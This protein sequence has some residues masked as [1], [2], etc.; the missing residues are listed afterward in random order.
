M[1]KLNTILCIAVVSLI[2]YPGCKKDTGS[3]VIQPPPPPSPLLIS[4]DYN[5]SYPTEVHHTL[6]F[7]AS[8]HL[9]QIR[10]TYTNGGST[11]GYFRRYTWTGKEVQSKEFFLD[12]TEIANSS[13]TLKFNTYNFK[14][15][16]VYSMFDLSSN[17]YLEYNSQFEYNDDLYL[18]K[19]SSYKSATNGLSYIFDYH[20]N[21][22]NRLDSISGYGMNSTNNILQKFQ[23]WVFEYDETKKNT[24][25]NFWMSSAMDDPLNTGGKA[26]RDVLSKATLI[27]DNNNGIPGRLRVEEDSYTNQ[28]DNKGLLVS[29]SMVSKYFAADGTVADSLTGTYRYTYQ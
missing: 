13:A 14:G 27:Y 11:N 16:Y 15:S 23:V 18:I 1:Y 21:N 28:S 6:Q 17:S 5:D 22:N 26:Q 7:D 10:T 8:R 20:Y 2:L 3:P 9:Q 24:I 19:I 25:G 4:V 29:R 12:N